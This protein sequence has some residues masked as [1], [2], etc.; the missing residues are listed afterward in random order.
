MMSQS[1][2]SL[3]LQ[4]SHD[5]SDSCFDVTRRGQY[6]AETDTKP[7]PRVSYKPCRLTLGANSGT[8][9]KRPE[10]ILRKRLENWWNWHHY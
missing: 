8:R 4:G 2:G 5:L 7:D 6:G 3:H 10:Q 1:A 9:G